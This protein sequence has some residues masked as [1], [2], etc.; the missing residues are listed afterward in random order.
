MAIDAANA[1]VATALALGAANRCSAGTDAA[2]PTNVCGRVKR[3]TT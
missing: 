3:Q 1:G 2:V